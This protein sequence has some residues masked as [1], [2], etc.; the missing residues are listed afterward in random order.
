[1]NGAFQSSGSNPPRPQPEATPPPRIPDHELLRLIGRGSYGE[2]WLARSVMGTFRAVKIVYRHTFETSH[3]FEREF[4]GIQKFEPISRSHQGLINVLHVG[5]SESGDAFYYVMELADDVNTG[6][7]IDIAAYK[8]RTLRSEIARNG[9]LPLDECVRVSLSL[10]SALGHLHQRGLIHRDLKP[11]NIIFVNGLP[12]LADIGLVSAPGEARSFVGTEGFIPPEGPG[13]AQADI[14]SLGKVLYEMS[15]GKDRMEFPALPTEW[16][17]LSHQ[18]PELEFHEIL[19]KA[20][21]GKA[22]NRYESAEELHADLA[23]LQSGRSVRKLRAL[24]R[25]LKTAKKLGRVAAVLAVLAAVGYFFAQIEARRARQ[26]ERTANE[27]LVKAYLAQARAGRMSGA[28]GQRIESLKAAAAAARLQPSME[29]RNEA[30]AALAL[31]DVEDLHWHE[32][33]VFATENLAFDEAQERYALGNRRG[34]ITIYRAADDSELMRLA[35]AGSA[36]RYLQFSPG[37]QFLAVTFDNARLIIWNLTTRAP[38]VNAKLGLISWG[39]HCVFSPDGRTVGIRVPAPRIAFFDL[40]SGD[41]LESLPLDSPAKFFALRPDGEMLAVG[42]HSSTNLEIWNLKSQKLYRHLTHEVPLESAAWHCDGRRLAIGGWAGHLYLWDT[43]TTNRLEMHGHTGLIP[44]VRFDRRGTVLVS[45]SWDGTSRFWSAATG[46]QLLA[47]YGGY[48]MGF[49]SDDQRLAYYREG[50]GLGLWRVHGSTVLRI[51]ASPIGSAKP[52]FTHV[53]LS[54]DGRWLVSANRQ[55]LHVWDFLSE[56]LV[57]SQPLRSGCSAYFTPDGQSLITVDFTDVR[58]WPLTSNHSNFMVGEPKILMTLPANTYPQVT[59]TRGAHET[60]TVYHSQ[61]VTALDLHS[62][63]PTPLIESKLLT[64]F[65]AI[66]SDTNWLAMTR[67][68]G[69]TQVWDLRRHEV[70]RE[71]G[72]EEWGP[73]SFSPDG[74]WLVLASETGY[75]FYETA[76]W[77]RRHLIKPDAAAALHPASVAF[78]HNGELAALAVSRRL[79]KIIDPATGREIVTLTP[80]RPEVITALSFSPDDRILL[81]ANDQKETQIWDL[82]ALRQELAALNLDWKD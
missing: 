24:E 30:V 38:V 39:P 32:S 50:L 10:A 53:D 65:A 54:P 33:P 63:V 17:E 7:A 68:D 56:R 29:L 69:T 78:S 55:E 14:F 11:S 67:P 9:R 72:A 3:P 46:Q 19:L 41:E 1:M 40:S 13:S 18:Q 77:Q 6:S 2:V 73:L 12:K 60:M 58:Q 70:V 27:H 76:S 5:R 15:T 37:G 21:E 47:S 8:P 81:V 42:G 45:S 43:E 28:P 44:N 20:C 51:I 25:R 64:G 35:G 26:A 57:H 80:P 59:V 4:A 74:R 31:L 79:V 52:Y 16:L 48:A 82:R 23:L 36:A 66:S 34:E 75:A 71:L 61:G 22:E 49:S 62:P